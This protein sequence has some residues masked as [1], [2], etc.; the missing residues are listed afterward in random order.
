MRFVV[1][2]GVIMSVFFRASNARKLGLLSLSSL[3]TVKSSLRPSSSCAASSTVVDIASN[4]LADK[5]GLPKFAEIAP[6]HVLPAVERDLAEL[7]EA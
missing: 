2:V 7:K 5:S 4:P 1:V 6:E 3:L